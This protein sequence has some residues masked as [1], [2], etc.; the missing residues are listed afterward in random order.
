MQRQY[1]NCVKFVSSSHQYIQILLLILKTY[2]KNKKHGKCLQLGI[3]LSLQNIY[4]GKLTIDSI[5][6]CKINVHFS[7]KKK[8]VCLFICVTIIEMLVGDWREGERRSGGR[9]EHP[10]SLACPTP[11][12]LPITEKKTIRH[13]D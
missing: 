5:C 11:S 6:L 1:F 2:R 10:S 9:R 4:I 7:M 8:I 12:S 13:T 3:F